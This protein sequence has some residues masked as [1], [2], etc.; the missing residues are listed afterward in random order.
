MS[1]TTLL[2]LAS[3]A[4]AGWAMAF[5]VADDHHGGG[6]PQ[7]DGVA[8]LE[9]ALH[10]HAHDK[11][12]PPHGHPFVTCGPAP[13]PARHELLIVAMVG[14]AAE[15]VIALSFGRRLP[16]SRGSPH[17]PPPWRESPSVLRI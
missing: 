16:A 10:G 2:V 6:S 15:S 5:H 9:I 17:D 3:S 11:G 7:D 8:G 12:A 4:A 13:I 1:V 14:D